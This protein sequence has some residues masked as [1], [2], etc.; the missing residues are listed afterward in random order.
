MRSFWVEMESVNA[1]A[2]GLA[3]ANLQAHAVAMRCN[4]QLLAEAYASAERTAA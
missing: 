4:L 1:R 2:W 3:A